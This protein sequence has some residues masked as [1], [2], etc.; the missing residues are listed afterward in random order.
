MATVPPFRQVVDIVRETK[1]EA[2]ILCCQYH[3]RSGT[4]TS[5]ADAIQAKDTSELVQ[6]AT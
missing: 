3:L 4:Y 1:G 2:F 5:N 6:E